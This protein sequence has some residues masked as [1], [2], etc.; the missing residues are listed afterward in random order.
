IHVDL[1]TWVPKLFKRYYADSYI[2]IVEKHPTLWGYLY[3]TTDEQKPDSRAYKLREAFE[4]LNT[5][6]FESKLAALKPDAVLTTHFLPAQLLARM[7]ARK[8]LD[9]PV[10]VQVTDYDIHQ[11]WIHEHMT[12]YFAG[13]REVAFRMAARGID[14]KIIHVTGIPIVPAFSA[15]L[16]REVCA[17]EIGLDPKKTTGLI[18]AGGAGLGGMEALVERLVRVPGDFQLIAL[19]GRNEKMLKSLQQLARQFP[20]KLFP[21]GFTTTIER[22]MVASDFAVTKPGGLS[23]SE[24]LAMHL[25]MI[26]TSPIPGQEE[27]NADFLLESGAALKAND[28]A[29]L[30]FRV[31]E[32]LADPARLAHLRER[33]RAIARPNAARDVLDIVF[34]PQPATVS[35]KGIGV[36]SI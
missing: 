5:R 34:D 16:S 6:K 7:I 11:L 29:G 21:H 8:H 25:P 27:R 19:A 20:G 1:M 14:P 18:M 2:K 31:R 33:A 15:K 4:R 36:E 26:L 17:R 30:E 12:G 10:W 28:A 23:T 3:K 9:R 13:N 32:L 22:L 35:R 24:C